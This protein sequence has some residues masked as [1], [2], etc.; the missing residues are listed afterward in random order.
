MSD[1]QAATAHEEQ[2]S[3]RASQFRIWAIV[4]LLA[5][6]FALAIVDRVI[7]SMMIGP[8]KADLALSDSAFGLAQGA[9]V[10]LFYLIFAVPFGWASD[11]FDRRWILFLGISVWSLASAACGLVRNFGELFAARSLVGA[12]EAVLGPAGYPMI[13]GLVQR[14]RLPLAMMIF[15]LGGNFGNALGQFLG[16]SLLSWLNQYGDISVWPVGE[17]APWRV[18]FLLTGLP[19]LALALMIF[20]APRQ[21]ADS[22]KPVAKDQANSGRFGVFFR[23]HK[24]FYLSH[25]IG[26]GLQQ[27]A[28]MATI[29]WNAAFM[30]RTYGWTPGQIGIVFGSI[31]L[32]TSAAAVI[33]HTWIMSR[34]FAKGMKDAHLRWQLIMSCMSI[35]MLAIAYLWPHPVAAC[36]GFGMASLFNGG[37]VVAGPTSLQLATPPDLRG[38]V[39]GLYV[40]VATML[41]TAIG[42]SSIGFVTDYI[43][44]NEQRVG[45]ALAGS[46]ILFCI[47]AAI[48]FGTGLA[49][50]RR[51][52]AASERPVASR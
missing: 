10:A 45:I 29:L 51:I 20:L 27:A 33:G 50:T 17:L 2:R 19:G 34:L 18:V 40:V 4:L 3:S 39:S 31:L 5:V 25:N 35:P 43:L 36:I 9:A 47:G 46:C 42:P 1:I 6:I 37:S 24:R 23:E 22:P 32:S 41:G 49:A 13:A 11:R 28:L 52:M 44:G 12:G 8:I 30:T 21:K 16:G 15:Y 7:L 14:N 48:A 26:M 38:R